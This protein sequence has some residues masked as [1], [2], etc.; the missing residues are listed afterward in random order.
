MKDVEPPAEGGSPEDDTRQDA[1]P[2]GLG[3]LA[4]ERGNTAA[5]AQQVAGGGHTHAAE[6][7]V[8]T[9]EAAGAFAGVLIDGFR[10][11]EVRL[12]PVL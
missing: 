8:G 5:I 9:V 4:A 11:P 2:G 6:H 3:G 10:V 7:D 12:A 1:E